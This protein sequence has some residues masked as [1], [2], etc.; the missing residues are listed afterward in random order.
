[1][2]SDA[3]VMQEIKPVLSGRYTMVVIE[4]TGKAFAA[5]NWPID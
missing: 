3:R 4:H 1:M 5:L 2:V